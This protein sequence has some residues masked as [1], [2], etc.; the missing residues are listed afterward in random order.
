MSID[1]PPP[2]VASTGA[3]D[4]CAIADAL[5][6]EPV[7]RAIYVND[8]V[9]NALALW[10]IFFWARAPTT[11][12]TFAIVSFDLRVKMRSKCGQATL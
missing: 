4:V 1:Q 12:R 5:R 3:A 9:A 6:R 7:M 8:V 11:R 10:F 2:F